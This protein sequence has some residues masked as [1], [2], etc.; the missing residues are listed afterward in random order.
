[1]KKYKYLTFLSLS[2]VFAACNKEKKNEENQIS[3]DSSKLKQTYSLNES[4]VLQLNNTPTVDSVHYF[5]NDK[6]IGSVK[7]NTPLDYNLASEKHGIY[8]LKA[9]AFINKEQAESTATINV[10]SAT[11]PTILSYTIVNTY[12]HDVKAYTQGLEFYGD[13]LIESTGNGEGIG[14]RTKGKSS[15]RKVNPKTGEVLKI[16]ELNDAVF[17]EGATVLNNKIYQLTY[18]NNEA[19]IYNLETLQNEKTLPYFKNTEGWGLTNDGKVLYMTDGSDKVYKV[20]PTD[21]SLIDYFVVSI[22]NGTVASVN[23][24]EWV[25]GEIYAN[26]YTQDAIGIFNPTNGTVTG[27]IDLSDLKSKVTQHP[28]LD[29]LNGIAYNKK[30]GT[31]FVTGKNWDKMFEIR[32][33]K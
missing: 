5:L 25:D 21:F 9:V 22:P 15:I 19:Y 30:S 32:I 2:L 11:Q 3:I 26:F 23:E 10:F 33:N 17:G 20:N 24:L 31:F 12:P 13:V 14:T 1:M 4:V 8:T 6:K 16:N 18:K 29:V 7:N 28:D 27:V